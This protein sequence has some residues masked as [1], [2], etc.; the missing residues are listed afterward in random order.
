MAEGSVISRLAACFWCRRRAV[1]FAMFGAVILVFVASSTI[2]ANSFCKTAANCLPPNTIAAPQPNTNL[3]WHGFEFDDKNFNI[4]NRLRAKL[5]LARAKFPTLESCLDGPSNQKSLTT[6]GL[7]WS[8]YETDEEK[9]ICL[10]RYFSKFPS[11]QAIIDW[12]F[13]SKFEVYPPIITKEPRGFGSYNVDGPYN[14][15]PIYQINTGFPQ[16]GLN[17]VGSPSDILSSKDDKRQANEVAFFYSLK[18][19]LI[20]THVRLIGPWEK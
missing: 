3:L 14:D 4:D 17:L 9:S 15:S 7:A 20:H 11:A 2:F 13:S 16:R 8:L 5:I 19:G 18:Y 1:S 10:F 6:S 12:L